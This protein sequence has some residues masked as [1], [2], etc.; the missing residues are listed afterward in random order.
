MLEHLT[1][2]NTS[3]KEQME[4]YKS[5][6]GTLTDKVNELESSSEKMKKLLY[7]VGAVSVVS[8]ILGLMQFV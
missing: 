5:V 2:S 7:G 3:Y 4:H 1:E 6:V 8:I